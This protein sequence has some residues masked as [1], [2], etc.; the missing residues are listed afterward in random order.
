M[1]E[2]WKKKFVF[3]WFCQI[4]VSRD[5]NYCNFRHL[6]GIGTPVNDRSLRFRIIVELVPRFSVDLR[7]PMTGE[8][9]KFKD[10]DSGFF[11][12]KCLKK[13]SYVFFLFF[14]DSR[15]WLPSR[16]HE[17]NLNWLE[18]IYLF[19]ATE[20][21]K[22]LEFFVVILPINFSRALSMSLQIRRVQGQGKC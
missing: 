12:A 3:A 4:L 21:V 2:T 17:N 7:F 8:F 11:L 13:Y 18:T 19:I 5:E 22:H 15:P 9:S 20:N 10:E 16:I 14:C 6:F 1:Y